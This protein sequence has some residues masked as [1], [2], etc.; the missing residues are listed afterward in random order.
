MR[1]S[2]RVRPS[3]V[4]FLLLLVSLAGATQQALPPPPSSAR[5]LLV[6]RKI[7]SGEH[8]TLAVLDV[9]GRLTPN[10]KI[11]F[12]NGDRLTTDATGRALFV[13]PLNTGTISAVISGRPG[14]V[15]TTVVSPMDAASE[16]IEVLFAPR[17]ASLTDR[18]ELVG[19]GFCGDADANHVTAAGKP[20]LVL[21]SSPLFLAILPPSDLEPGAT[22]V[23]VTC[24]KRPAMEFTVKFV[25][26]TL[27]ADS[28]ALAPGEHRTLTVH[29]RGTSQ[30]VGLQANNLAPDVATLSGPVPARIS[31][32]GGDD[33]VGR[34]EVVG[35]QRGSF[36]ISIRLLPSQSPPRR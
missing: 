32:T 10:V 11:V 15:L 16:T 33:N 20:A 36:L 14:R 5:I 34:F 13:A 27:E 29:V 31:S 3:I 6:P 22:S 19:R 17:V 23:E 25:E 8:A 12:S 24:G 1:W 30:K 9:N 21:V 7:V 18:F 4:V 28:S 2:Q 35:R 26:L